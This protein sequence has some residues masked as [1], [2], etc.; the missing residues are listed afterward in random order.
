MGTPP[1]LYPF[2]SFPRSEILEML[3][4]AD[5]ISVILPFPGR[6][7]L[8]VALT[9]ETT[10]LEAKQAVAASLGW[11]TGLDMAAIWS[12]AKERVLTA[13]FAHPLLRLCF[14]MVDICCH[15][16]SMR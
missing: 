10:A 3:P 12:V 1:P 15:P 11:T 6:P 13:A 7:E 9:D 16:P 8:G 2:P 4:D 14:G 5:M